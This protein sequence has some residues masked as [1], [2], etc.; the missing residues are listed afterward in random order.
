MVNHSLD[1]SRSLDHFIC[2][3][4]QIYM[5]MLPFCLRGQAYYFRI[6]TSRGDSL[7]NGSDMLYTMHKLLDLITWERTSKSIWPRFKPKANWFLEI[8]F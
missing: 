3:H 1:S 4:V 7:S 5:N 2:G 8:W 6:E